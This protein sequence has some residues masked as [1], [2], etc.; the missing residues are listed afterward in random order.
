MTFALYYALGACL[1]AL[2]LIAARRRGGRPPAAYSR[3]DWMRLAQW[4]AAWPLLFIVLIASMIDL[5]RG[6]RIRYA[7]VKERDLAEIAARR[8][9]QQAAWRATKEL[10]R[11]RKMEASR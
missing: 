11:I 8:A 4:T 5:I 9:R 3:T 2:L 7:L 10:N 1:G 6:G